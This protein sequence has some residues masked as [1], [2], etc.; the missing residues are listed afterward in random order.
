MCELISVR[1][2]ILFLIHIPFV[3]V[4]PNNDCFCAVFERNGVHF[5]GMFGTEKDR[6]HYTSQKNF[7]MFDLTTFSTHPS[8]WIPTQSKLKLQLKTY[9]DKSIVELNRSPSGSLDNTSPALLKQ[10]SPW[11]LVWVL[12]GRFYCCCCCFIFALRFK[13]RHKGSN[14]FKQENVGCFKWKASANCQYNI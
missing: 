10:S 1:R 11:V 8:I 14:K 7:Y 2:K 4:L 13:S 5:S 12:F 6:Q 3:L 9:S